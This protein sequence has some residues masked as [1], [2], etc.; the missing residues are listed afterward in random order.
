MRDISSIFDYFKK[1]FHLNKSNKELYY[2]Q[3][4]FIIIQATMFVV[5]GVLMYQLVIDVSAGQFTEFDLA[6]HMKSILW[7][8][9]SLLV[10]LGFGSVIMEAGLF[11][12]YKQ[13]LTGEP[14]DMS[15]FTDGVSKYFFKMLW[16]SLM[17]MLIWLVILIPYVIIGFLTLF[18]GFF[19]IPVVIGIFTAMWKVSIVMDDLTV[20]EGFRKGFE[21]AKENFKPLAA[22]VVVKSAFLASGGGS[23]N[24]GGGNSGS[25]MNSNFSNNNNFTENIDIPDVSPGFDGMGF[26]EAMNQA[27]PYIKTGFYVLIPVITVAIIIGALIKMVFEIFFNLSIFVMYQ[28]VEYNTLTDEEAKLKTDPLA[29]FDMEVE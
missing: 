28:D 19:F 21:F 10:I 22:L 16:A 7:W 15:V 23:G 2:P 26:E 18:T 12:M 9:L 6:G 29:E 20:M 11:N 14:L 5:F 13:S 8:G 25:N 17:L 27:L 3:I 1:A 4:A 24:S